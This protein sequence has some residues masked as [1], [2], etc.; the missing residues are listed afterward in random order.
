MQLL[1]I[2]IP[3]NSYRAT[4][5]RALDSIDRTV[6]NVIIVHDTYECGS[7][8]VSQIALENDCQYI[9]HNPGYSSL[10]N[11]QMQLGYNAVRTPYIAN[12]GDD[13]VYEEDVFHWIHNKLTEQQI[14]ND[15]Q[16]IMGRAVLHPASHRGSQSDSI[17][18]WQEPKLIRGC[19]TGQCF[20]T[21]NIPSK[22][23][24]WTDDFTFMLTTIQNFGRIEWSTKILQQCY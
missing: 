1:T 11:E 2:V 6:A 5:Q 21:P 14:N 13:D 24:P 7:V 15:I 8:N 9:E 3:T 20:I 10:G 17:V 18:L 4:L 12:M 22:L 19:I 16:P 23:G